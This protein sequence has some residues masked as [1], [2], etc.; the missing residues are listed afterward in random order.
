MNPLWWL[1]LRISG[2]VK[3][4][5]YLLLA[6]FGIVGLAT[7]MSYNFLLEDRTNKAAIG[8][9]YSVWAGIISGAQAIFLL[10][11]VPGA[12][13]RAVQRDYQLGMVESLR[14]TP[15]SDTRVIIGYLIGPAIPPL[16]L[17]LPGL[18]MG[19]YFSMQAANNSG[20]GQ[21][22]GTSGVLG[23]WFGL[24][25]LL[26]IGALMIASISLLS[27]IAVR[28]HKFNIMGLLVAGSVLGGPVAVFV[29]PGLALLT[30]VMSGSILVS[31]LGRQVAMGDNASLATAALMQALFSLTFLAAAARRYRHPER[32]VF[33]LGLGLVL[34]SL[35]GLTLLLGIVHASGSTQWR[36]PIQ[37]QLAA[38]LVAFM[39]TGMFVLNAAA[40][41]RLRFDRATR[42]D[43]ARYRPLAVRRSLVPVLLTVASSL[44]VVL[45]VTVLHE[46]RVSETLLLT[47]DEPYLWMAIV[48]AVLFAAWFDYLLLYIGAAL[49]WK[50]W[51]ILLISWGVL[52]IAPVLIDRWVTETYHEIYAVEGEVI[53][54]PLEQYLMACS[55]LGTIWLTFD[56]CYQIG[57]GLAVQLALVMLAAWIARLVQPRNVEP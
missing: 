39:A 1:H 38:S 18:L 6:Y 21:A 35:T 42:F 16:L 48:L 45:M 32:P 4:N 27:A 30:G 2:N 40:H 47:M 50:T 55:P 41:D 12:I 34:L 3:S 44:L 20:I 33:P 36:S 31:S 14:L 24:M 46:N 17:F 53:R 11:L 57:A 43:P 26:L 49:R 22:L 7:T 8:G 9:F 25:G 23:M 13:K 10:L 19:A 37:D 51:I 29:V 54:W 52:K 56:P 28:E 5:L 15:M